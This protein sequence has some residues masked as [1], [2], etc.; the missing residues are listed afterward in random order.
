MT[1]Q[2]SFIARDYPMR[3]KKGYLMTMLK[4]ERGVPDVSLYL[5]PNIDCDLREA[6]FVNEVEC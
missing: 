3:R 5:V 4:D 2:V 6:L 1:Q